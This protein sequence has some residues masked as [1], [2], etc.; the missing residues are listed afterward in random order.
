MQR[1]RAVKKVEVAPE[2][3]KSRELVI[4]TGITTRCCCPGA[5]AAR[6]VA[7]PLVT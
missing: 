1:K 6:G 4:L 5:V 2:P 3:A 7:D